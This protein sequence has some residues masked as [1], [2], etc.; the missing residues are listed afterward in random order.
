M[1]SLV[2][3]AAQIF[4]LTRNIPNVK[5]G[6]NLAELAISKVCSYIHIQNQGFVLMPC[7]GLWTCFYVALSR[8]EQMATEAK[9][10][11][12]SPAKGEKAPVH[13]ILGDLGGGQIFS[14]HW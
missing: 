6:K 4:Q 9:L 11:G 7:S 13:V 8:T 1:L 10:R 14:I 2:A 5:N 3:C 12:T